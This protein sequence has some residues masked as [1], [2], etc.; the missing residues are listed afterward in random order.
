[1]SYWLKIYNIKKEKDVQKYEVLS[2]KVKSFKF[3]GQMV[4]KTSSVMF[5]QHDKT[6]VLLKMW[7][8]YFIILWRKKNKIGYFN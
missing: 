6:D 7:V 3:I 5:Q 2:A 8:P 4:Q 1:M